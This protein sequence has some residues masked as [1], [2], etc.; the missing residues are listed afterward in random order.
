M[1]FGWK[2]IIIIGK[3]SDLLGRPIPGPWARE[4]KIFLELCFCVLIGIFRLP[5]SPIFTSVGIY[6]AKR[7]LRN[8]TTELFFRSQGLQIFAFFS[9]A[10]KVLLNLFYI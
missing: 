6:R 1:V 9:K 5:A 4:S 8:F 2:E 3:F 10:F 7:K